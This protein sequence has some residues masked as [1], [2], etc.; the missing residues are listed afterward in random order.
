MLGRSLGRGVRQSGSFSAIPPPVPIS[1]EVKA[2]STAQE[3]P[4]ALSLH[5][6]PLP[7]RPSRWH[8]LLS[9][10]HPTPAAQEARGLPSALDSR[11]LC[12]CRSP[13][14]NILQIPPGPSPPT[15]V[16]SS[17]APL[18]RPSLPTHFKAAPGPLQAPSL[19]FFSASFSG[20]T[21]TTTRHTMDFTRICVPRQWD[22]SSAGLKL[23]VSVRLHP[24][25]RLILSS[26]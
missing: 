10:T 1:S 20:I 3:V 5:R 25:A 7:Y 19:A 12:T 15:G 11:E 8:H 16:C 2:A 22:T 14:E 13:A 18:E 9:S 26:H 23:F 21:L 6:R 4:R 17:T 24:W